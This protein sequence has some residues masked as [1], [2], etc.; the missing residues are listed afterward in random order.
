[1]SQVYV[2]SAIQRTRMTE[3]RRASLHGGETTD[4]VGRLVP[5]LSLRPLDRGAIHDNGVLESLDVQEAL[6]AMGLISMRAGRVQVETG[7]ISKQREKAS[8][9]FKSAPE[10]PANS[11]SNAFRAEDM[12][13]R[14]SPPSG[15]S[16]I[17]G[18]GLVTQGRIE[19]VVD[20]APRGRA[21]ADIQFTR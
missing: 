3:P 18:I 4:G 19:C 8:N 7:T 14:F 20:D 13:V 16:R 9:V 6:A 21:A 5:T 2:R 11:P 15:G 12:V 10:R 17:Q 1:M